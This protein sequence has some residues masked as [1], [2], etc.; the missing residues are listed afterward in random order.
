M[1]A[2]V[3]GCGTA[4]GKERIPVALLNEN[5]STPARWGWSPG[6]GRDKQSD[7]SDQHVGDVGGGACARLCDRALF[8]K[9]QAQS[10]H[11]RC[12]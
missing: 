11:D 5:E 8:C 6:P 12:H 2:G 4:R 3:F 1:R 9:R 7:S 10:R